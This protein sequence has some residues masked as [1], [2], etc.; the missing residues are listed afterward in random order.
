MSLIIIDFQSCIVVHIVCKRWGW[1]WYVSWIGLPQ[2]RMWWGGTPAPY[3]DH[4]GSWNSHFSWGESAVL[5][6][7]YGRVSLAPATVKCEKWYK[8]LCFVCVRAIIFFI[9]ALC[10]VIWRRATRV[11]ISARL[12]LRPV[13]VLRRLTKIIVGHCTWI[14]VLSMNSRTKPNRL[15]AAEVNPYWWS[16]RVTTGGLK[17]SGGARL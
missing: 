8:C 6:C 1:D 12:P 13:T 11:S 16:T 14:A 10:V 5:W 7:C 17:A 2:M 15:K 9:C 3:S 4:F